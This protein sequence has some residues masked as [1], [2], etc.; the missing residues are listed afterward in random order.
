MS[1]I[2]VAGGGISGLAVALGLSRQGRHRIEVFERNAQ[3]AELGAG[4][5][6]APNAFHALDLLGVCDQVRSRAVYIDELVLRD[7]RSGERLVTLPVGADY[8]RRFGNPYAVVHRGDLYAPLL[9][10]CR[11]EER[12]RL[13]ADSPVVGYRTSDE[14]VVCEL[15][16]GEQV[17]G[18]VLIGADGIRSRVR[19]QLVGDGEPRVTGHTI[20]RS[21]VPTSSVP[22]ELRWN[23]V[24]LWAGEGWHLVSYPIAGGRELNIAAVRD[25]GATR[26]VSGEPV[27]QHLVP[28]A[29]PE[30]G[31]QARRLLHLGRQWRR[32]VLCDRPP[33]ARWV[34]GRVVLIGDAAHPM[35]QYAAQGAA[36]AL[37]DSVVLARSLRCDPDEIPGRLLHFNEVRRERTSRAQEA[38]RWL[39][40]EL[41]HPAGVRART[42]DAMLKSMTADDLMEAV[43]WVHGFRLGAQEAS[44]APP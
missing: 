39:G 40:D 11:A 34:Q 12:I 7:G 41:Y 20:F 4:I 27:D 9:A 21:V 5:Q 15:A 33:V 24:S 3:F 22:A 19:H 31:G 30:A 18:D 26:A 16:S 42:R 43:S 17:V 36:L 44:P 14:S 25:D 13:R 2:L 28:A 38:A 8:R 29:F 1:T 23:A 32:W 10:A 6:L 37:E 35:L